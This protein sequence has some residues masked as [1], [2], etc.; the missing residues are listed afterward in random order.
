[1]RLLHELNWRW[2]LLEHL[3]AR[4]LSSDVSEHLDVMLPFEMYSKMYQVQED[5]TGDGLDVL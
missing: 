3:K 4:N 2:H 5:L 1:M